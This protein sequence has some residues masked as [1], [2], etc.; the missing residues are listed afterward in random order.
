[1]RI[2]FMNP[3]AQS[4]ACLSEAEGDACTFNRTPGRLREFS[5]CSRFGLV[6]KAGKGTSFTRATSVPT[7][8][9]LQPLRYL[10]E[11]ALSFRPKP[12]AGSQ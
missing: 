2:R 8:A 11:N 12:E 10:S 6:S 4:K 7:V 3:H 1:M 9:W 5:P